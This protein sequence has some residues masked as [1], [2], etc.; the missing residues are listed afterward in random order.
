[1]IQD[2]YRL[3]EGMKRVGYDADTQRY[4]F[5]D[6]SGNYW[7]GPEG[8]EY[9]VM[10]KGTYSFRLVPL[11]LLTLVVSCS[12]RGIEANIGSSSKIE[13]ERSIIAQQYS[14]DQIPTG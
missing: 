4:S 3:P 10:T 6:Q 1:M 8:Q 14:L 7:E 13:V 11:K 2:D 5:V 12:E 9:G